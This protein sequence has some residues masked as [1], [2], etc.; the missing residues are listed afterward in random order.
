MVYVCVPVVVV[1]I[2][3]LMFGTVII[4]SVERC[5]LVVSYCSRVVVIYI[6]CNL[7]V[8][9]LSTMFI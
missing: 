1:G 8:I 2:P 6:S 5:T 3:V 4:G 9:A 7:L